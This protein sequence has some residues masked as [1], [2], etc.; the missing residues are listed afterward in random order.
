MLSGMRHPGILDRA[1]CAV[2][3][4]D[5]QEGFR[6]YVPQIA[7]ITPAIQLLLRA[8]ERMG[9]P[10]AWSEQYPKGLGRTI[11]ELT[12]L[13]PADGK[14][15]EKV[16]FAACDNPEWDDLPAPVRA[17][18]QFLIVGVEAHVCVRQTAL[19]LASGGR[20]ISIA[21]DAVASHDALHCD[22]ALAALAREG[23]RLTT[24]EQAIF[25]LLGEA[26]TPE[27][28]DVQQLVIDHV[29]A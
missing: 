10:I 16:T 9:L 21:V 27:F 13:L 4:I 18:H 3:V 15:L 29:K 6:D 20:E 5:V 24:V 12:D 11:S 2:L 17:A 8:A 23:V 22:T 1:H 25:D 7:H 14:P 28:R 26:G 19:A